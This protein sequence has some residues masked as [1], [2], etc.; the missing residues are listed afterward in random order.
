MWENGKS[1]KI[2]I[3]IS[4]STHTG[5][6]KYSNGDNNVYQVD[7]FTTIYEANVMNK[8]ENKRGKKIE[9]SAC[10][11]YNFLLSRHIFFL[12]RLPGAGALGAKCRKIA[13]ALFL[14]ERLASGFTLNSSYRYC[15]LVVATELLQCSCAMSCYRPN[16]QTP[17]YAKDVGMVRQDRNSHRLSKCISNMQSE[18]FILLITP[19]T[20]CFSFPHSK[21]GLFFSNFHPSKVRPNILCD[22]LSIWIQYSLEIT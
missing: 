9:Y 21:N 12:C 10:M 20:I 22:K 15:L 1:Q 17:S 18:Y 2:A 4:L 11:L 13:S 7:F 5:Y 8:I 16:Q 3:L 14:N 19:Y 6:Q